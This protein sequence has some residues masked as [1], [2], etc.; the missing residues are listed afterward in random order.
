M[1]KGKKKADSVETWERGKKQEEQ[2]KGEQD[3]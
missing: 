3:K 1:K 2:R